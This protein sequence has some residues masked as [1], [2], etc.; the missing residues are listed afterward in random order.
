MHYGR[1]QLSTKLDSVLCANTPVGRRG[2]SLIMA[3][4]GRLGPKGVMF[5]GFR[6]MKG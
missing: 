2:C 4:M 6:Y 5:S 1:A 3:Y